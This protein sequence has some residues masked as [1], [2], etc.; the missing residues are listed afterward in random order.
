MAGCCVF[1]CTNRNTQEGLNLYRI[2][3]DSRP[4]LQAI[5][6]VDTINNAFV[7]SAHF[8]SG[9]SSLDWQSPDFVPS[10]FVYTKQSKRPEVKMERNEYDN[11]N[12]R[13]RQLQDEYVNLKQEF[14]K[15]QAENH[16][17]KEKLEK[18]TISCSTVKSHIGKLFFFPPLG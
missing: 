11:L 1:G 18:S 16:K 15:P 7:C 2:P 12:L 10:V 8:I 17:L 4:F 6:R 14:T 3:R 13:H 9:K 5:K